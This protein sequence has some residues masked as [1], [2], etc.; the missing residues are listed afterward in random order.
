M[1]ET[2][3]LNLKKSHSGHIKL[4]KSYQSLVQIPDSD[5]IYK[6][7]PFCTK[8]DQYGV[9]VF[10][11]EIV[12]ENGLSASIIVPKSS[13]IMAAA[14]NHMLSM[15]ESDS[16]IVEM[17]FNITLPCCDGD[18][19]VTN[20]KLL[21]T[22]RFL[23]KYKTRISAASSKKSDPKP[24]LAEK[25]THL[26]SSSK[27]VDNSLSESASHSFGNPDNVVTP[28]SINVH[29]VSSSAKR[30]LESRWQRSTN[31]KQKALSLT[32]PATFEESESEEEPVQSPAESIEPLKD[33]VPQKERSKYLLASRLV[34]KGMFADHEHFEFSGGAPEIK[35]TYKDEKGM[36]H[37]ALRRKCELAK[38]M[39]QCPAME[40]GWADSTGRATV[41]CKHSACGVN[42]HKSCFMQWHF[43]SK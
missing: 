13:K 29:E 36:S 20:V 37:V 38:A 12:R 30:D 8:S 15:K 33:P 9:F 22:D 35:R 21:S 6:L 17:D 2:F 16:G 40:R 18:I 43:A 25:S 19:H 3:H 31:K 41:V 11:K 24:T 26:S 23:D 14:N 34:K 5:L 1:S 28:L 4:K 27:S 7:S 32:L 10:P 42:L 39:G